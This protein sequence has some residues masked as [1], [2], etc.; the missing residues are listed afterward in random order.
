MRAGGSGFA[1]LAGMLRRLLLPLF[2]AFTLGL[3]PFTPTHLWEKLNR[4]AGESSDLTAVDWLDIALHGAPWIWLAVALVGVVYPI[5]MAATYDRFM[6]AIEERRLRGW[7]ADLLAPLSGRVLE[8]GAGTGA[9]LPHYPPSV[10]SIVACEPDP[11]MRRRLRRRAQD[12]R[13]VI[14][15]A[16]AEPLPFDDDHFDAVVVTLVLCTVPDPARA[17]AEIHRVLAPGG[18]LVFLE[19]VAADSAENASLARL[20][21]LLEPLWRPVGGGCNL[22]RRTLETLRDGGFELG[23]VQEHT[24]RRGGPLAGPFVWG[25]AAPHD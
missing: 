17:V 13:V 24:F 16:T 22:T 9:N 25:S 1:T 10:E 14:H 15:E 3:A 7:R 4:L 18:C 12:P 19:H 11:H 6:R 21:R 5:Y 2:A 20:Q 23:E 8:I